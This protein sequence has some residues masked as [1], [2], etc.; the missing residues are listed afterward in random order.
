[1]AAGGMGLMS[2]MLGRVYH[3]SSHELKPTAEVDVQA[4]LTDG[5]Q[6]RRYV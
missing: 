5:S 1:M 2:R 6:P 4:V 3:A